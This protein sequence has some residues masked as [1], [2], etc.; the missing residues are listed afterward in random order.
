RTTSP[1]PSSTSRSCMRSPSSSRTA[2]A[3][4]RSAAETSSTK[5]T[6]RGVLIVGPNATF[7]SYISQVLPS[8]AET[9]VLLRTLGELFPG[10]TAKGTEPAA[11]AEIKG[12][13]AMTE[14][15]AVAV[16]DRQHVP[17]EPS[18]VT[19]DRDTLLLYP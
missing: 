8:L 9:G 3:R 11:A 16:A 2:S 12:R 4:T 7:L 18:E 5:P 19:V 13:L 6:S 17:A 15:L 1:G 10:V 14:V